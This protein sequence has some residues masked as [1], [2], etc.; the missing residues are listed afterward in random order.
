M[1]LWPISE[2]RSYT[3][4]FHT[5]FLL[6]EANLVNSHLI[7][8]N[9]SPGHRNCIKEFRSIPCELAADHL[10][11]FPETTCTLD[12]AT[13]DQMLKFMFYNIGE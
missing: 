8:E 4:W 11:M 7:K 9:S 12:H 1:V 2:N 13:G 10:Q 3:K 6:Q 5:E